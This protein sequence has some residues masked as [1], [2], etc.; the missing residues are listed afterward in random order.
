MNFIT[1]GITVKD[2]AFI[3]GFIWFGLCIGIGVWKLVK[4]YHSIS[5]DVLKNINQEEDDK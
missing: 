2:I 4:T 3:F 5:D 1:D